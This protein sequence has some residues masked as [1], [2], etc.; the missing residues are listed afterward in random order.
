MKTYPFV[1]LSVAKSPLF[2]IPSLRGAKRRGNPLLLLHSVFARSEATW[3]SQ[4]CSPGFRIGF[5]TGGIPM[6]VK[7]KQVK[8]KRFKKGNSVKTKEAKPTILNTIFLN[9]QTTID[10]CIAIINTFEQ[11][12]YTTYYDSKTKVIKTKA[13]A[14]KDGR[15]RRELFASLRLPSAR[16]RVRKD[17]REK[18]GSSLRSERQKGMFSL[19]HLP[20]NL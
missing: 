11:E 7:T 20:Q 4:R 1:A 13:F 5:K 8:S 2:S 10:E 18:R 16:K 14:R 19:L 15:E 3:Q 9:L 12:G 17:G 6:K